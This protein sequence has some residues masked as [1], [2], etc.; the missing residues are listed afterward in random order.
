MVGFEPRC[1]CGHRAAQ[2][3]GPLVELAEVAA[4]DDGEFGRPPVVVEDG[5]GDAPREALLAEAG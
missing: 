1:D 2:F 4:Q 5:L 3:A